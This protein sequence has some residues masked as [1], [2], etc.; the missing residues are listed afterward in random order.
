M[1]Y[2]GFL[3]RKKLSSTKIIIIYKEG[4]RLRA[5]CRTA[6]E[7]KKNH[8]AMRIVVEHAI[9]CHLQYKNYRIMNDVFKNKKV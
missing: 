8:S 2:L 5:S 9:S 6:K 3:G 7:Y 4:E 1:F